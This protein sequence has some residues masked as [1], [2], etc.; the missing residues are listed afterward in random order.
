MNASLSTTDRDN[1]TRNNR[2]ASRQPHLAER[3]AALLLSRE[4]R[5][6]QKA[7]R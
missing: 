7:E 1:A 6:N 5:T 4:G 2:K 3:T